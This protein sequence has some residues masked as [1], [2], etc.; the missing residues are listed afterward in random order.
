M[1]NQQTLFSD[2]ESASEVRDEAR[3]EA[4]CQ[5]ERVQVLVPLPFAEPFDYVLPSPEQDAVLGA[6]VEIPVGK[7]RLVGVIWA[8]GAGDDSLSAAKIKPIT[9]LLDAPPMVGSLRKL[10]DFTAAYTLSPRGSVLKMSL[11]LFG[12]KDGVDAF[13]HRPM[14]QHVA[15]RSDGSDDNDSLTPKRLSVMDALRGQPPLSVTEAAETAGVS[16]GVVRAM[17]KSGLID[18]LDLPTDKSFPAMFYHTAQ[19]KQQA[20]SKQK[21]QL[22]EEQATASTAICEAVGDSRYESF[23]LEGVT[24]S[25]KTEVYFEAI[26]KAL[27]ASADSQVLVLLPE[28]ALTAQWL[29]RFEARFN[30]TPAQWHSD[31]GQAE[32]RRVWHGAG[33][34]NARVVVGAR[35]SLF[36][37]FKNLALIIVDEEHDQSFKQEEGV[38]YHARDMAVTRAF[39]ASCPIVL[40]SATPS[41][42]SLANV[43]SGRYSHL[44][45]KER[46]GGAQLPKIQA[47]DMRS[48]SLPANQWLSP[49]LADKITETLMWGEQ[50]ALFLN[51]RGYAPLTLC[52]TCGHRVECPH[53]SAWLVEHRSRQRLQCHHCGFDMP[54]LHK[55]PDCDSEDSLVA[56]GPG[57]ERLGEEVIELFPQARVAVMASDTMTS[58]SKMAAVVAQIEAGTVDIVIGTQMITK[59]YHFPNLTL[60]GVVDADLGLRGGDMRAGERTYQQLVQVAGR[61]GRAERPGQVYLQTF[62]PEHA[63]VQALLTGNGETYMAAEIDARRQYNMPPFGKLVALIL[64]GEDI[65]QV[66]DV[67]RRLAATAP[68]SED[69]RSMGPA[70]APMTKIRGQFRYRMLMQASKSVKVQSVISDWLARAGKLPSKVR[71][72]IDIDPYSFF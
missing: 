9:R 22:S 45:L 62:E 34:G 69:I 25:G 11:G 38:L 17:V 47:I 3:D 18:A 65:R 66:V 70:P 51:R 71:I 61:A 13:L 1:G 35:S 8:L 15:L 39:I 53:C 43:Q 36:L 37:P 10:I 60:V 50:T 12:G 52:R 72:K 59:G 49:K 46:H 4:V 67:G 32:K 16:A 20:A 5:G 40:A 28:I 57:V 30:V 54:S 31:V 7:R 6:Y 21:P 27:E 56:V 64:S 41:L 58:A 33:N 24:G 26:I 23:L 19:K 68:Q 14:V 48:D 2:T 55:C 29:Q 44:T 42:E 63:V